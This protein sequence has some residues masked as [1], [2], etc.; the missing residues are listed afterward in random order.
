M[1]K[2]ELQRFLRD[3][4][5]VP[6]L[7]EGFQRFKG[8]LEAQVCWANERGYSITLAEAEGLSGAGELSDDELEAAAGGWTG[9][10]TTDPSTGGTTGGTTTSGGSSS[11]P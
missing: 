10:P 3:L 5:T 4:G 2:S 11:T 9:D 8:D 6:E 7:A 1:S